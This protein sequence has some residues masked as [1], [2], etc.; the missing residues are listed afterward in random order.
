MSEPERPTPRVLVATVTTYKS[1]TLEDLAKAVTDD[2]RAAFSLIRS[3]MV[4]GDPEYIRQLVSSVATANEADAMIVVGGAGFGPF[5][6]TCEAI[7][8]LVERRIEGFG[9]AFRQMLREEF[10]VGPVALLARATAGVYS[11]CVVYALSGQPSQVR[12]AVET[13]IVPTLPDAIELA[14]G[15]MRAHVGRSN[16]D[17]MRPSIRPRQP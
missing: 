10:A 6:S 17:S 2:V 5:D 1:R 11:Q 4:K 15:R 13:L 16:P 9:E 7:D 8:G 3:V 14:T 12:R